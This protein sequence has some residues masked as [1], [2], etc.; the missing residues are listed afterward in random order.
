MAI[1]IP[2]PFDG[3]PSD[4]IFDQAIAL[5]LACGRN[6]AV[7]RDK[8]RTKVCALAGILNLELSNRGHPVPTPP[9]KA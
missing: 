2:N 7:T 8:H 6:K 9:Y 3:V 5:E 4:V 1:P